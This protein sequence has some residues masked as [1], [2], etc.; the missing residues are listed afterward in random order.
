M[1]IDGPFVLV[2]ALRLLLVFGALAGAFW[3]GKTYEQVKQ[4]E[5]L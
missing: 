2:D 3:A 5:E 1:D 4:K